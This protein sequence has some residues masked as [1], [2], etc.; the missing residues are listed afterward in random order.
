MWPLPVLKPVPLHLPFLPRSI[1][2]G[3]SLAVS[4]W[5]PQVVD[6]WQSLQSLRNSAY[7]LAVT[8]FIPALVVTCT[9]V[10]AESEIH[11][12]FK[13]GMGPKAFLNQIELNFLTPFDYSSWLIVQ[14]VSGHFGKQG[15]FFFQPGLLIH[16]LWSTSESKH[17]INLEFGFMSYF[18]PCKCLQACLGDSEL[19][20]TWAL[21][22]ELSRY[23]PKIVI[24]DLELHQFFN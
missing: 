21:S 16:P 23:V 10:L 8:W 11:V 24:F 1:E 9:W 15:C 5:H 19:G 20:I 4:A 6:M 17:Q 12:F 14:T 7:L 3:C 13:E 18:S 2:W 22:S